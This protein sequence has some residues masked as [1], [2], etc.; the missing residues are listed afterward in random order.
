M[1]LA[2]SALMS[3]MVAAPLQAGANATAA[4]SGGTTDGSKPKRIDDAAA[5]ASH[6]KMVETLAEIASHRDTHPFLGTKSLADLKPQLAALPAEAPVPQPLQLLDMVAYQELALGQTREAMERFKGALDLAAKANA[7]KERQILLLHM[8]TA[9]LRL[10]ENENC[11]HC[12]NGESC[13]LPVRGGGI[14]TKPE[15]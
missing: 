8:G 13:L 15:G 5:R 11:V 12:S 1:G 9:C 6:Q 3:W 4:G 10:G 14:H 7:A 2:T